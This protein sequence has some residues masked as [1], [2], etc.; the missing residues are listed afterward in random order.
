MEARKQA[1]C[2]GTRTPAIGTRLA[3]P[4]PRLAPLSHARRRPAP[5]PARPVRGQ[6]RPHRASRR[7]IGA[8]R[9][10]P[11]PG[12][13]DPTPAVCSVF[14]GKRRANSRRRP[15]H[16]HF[17]GCLQE[18]TFLA[19]EQQGEGSR[20]DCMSEARGTCV[21]PPFRALA[22]GTGLA[23]AGAARRR[24]QSGL[25]AHDDGMAWRGRLLDN[26]LGP[27]RAHAVVMGRR[28]DD[29]T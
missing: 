4:V 16:G 21:E 20:P 15:S 27:T 22:S 13:P 3:S 26:A 12:A 17:R 28:H 25:G 2:Q 24:P 5:G 23:F 8:A 14:H 19:V 11:A 29:D 9:P 18:G 10:R 6:R 1:T 7:G